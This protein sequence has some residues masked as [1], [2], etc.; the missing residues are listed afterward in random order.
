MKRLAIASEW[1]KKV[2]EVGGDHV[3]VS[4][5]EQSWVGRRDKGSRH[6]QG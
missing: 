2:G 6:G 3:L 1:V 4:L 5:N